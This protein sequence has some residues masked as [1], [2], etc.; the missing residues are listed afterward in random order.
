MGVVLD[1][2]HMA[3]MMDTNLVW[4]MEEVKR[5]VLLGAV[6]LV[7]HIRAMAM[8]TCPVELIL[9]AVHI[10]LYIQA[11]IWEVD[12][13]PAVVQDLIIKLSVFTRML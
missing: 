4:V 12:T 6:M 2:I 1:R 9:V 5:T 11:V 10:H 7:E 8:I 13:Y 3:Y